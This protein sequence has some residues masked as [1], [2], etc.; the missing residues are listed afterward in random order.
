MKNPISTGTV[1]TIQRF[2][3][4]DGPGIRTT[5]FL[6][7]CPLRCFWCHN[8]EGLRMKPEIQFES[9]HCIGCGECARV[10][11]QNA[12]VFEN[13]QRVYLRDRCVVCGDCLDVC[14]PEGLQRVGKEMTVDQVLQEILLDQAFYKSSG[15]GVTLS[16][17]EPFLQ[18]EFSLELLRKCQ[19]VGIQTAVETTTFTRWENIQAA[20]PET[21]L[22]MVDIKH[23]ESQK[24]QRGTGVPNDLILTNIQK[25]NQTGK[26]IIFRTPVIPGFNDSPAE[27]VAV[28]DFIQGLSKTREDGGRN[29]SLE[30]LPF[31]KLAADKYTSLGMQYQAADLEPLKKDHIKLLVDSTRSSGITVT[32]R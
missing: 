12:Q 1:F 2:S 30:L 25:L 17:G 18:V 19:A 7:G 32:S 14:Y 22:F 15:G 10:C 20:L 9:S 23:M 6:K 3:I 4:H 27:I 29:L 16:G 31:H 28:A 26:P 24:H 8:P 5:V 11:A 13:G 21:D